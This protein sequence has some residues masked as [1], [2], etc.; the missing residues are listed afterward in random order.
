M[1]EVEVAGLMEIAWWIL[2]YGDQ[3]EVVEPAEL[4]EMIRSHASNML[5]QYQEIDDSVRLNLA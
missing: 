2:G 1:F 5:R 4:R 3:A